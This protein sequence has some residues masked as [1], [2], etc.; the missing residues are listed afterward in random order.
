[1]EQVPGSEYDEDNGDGDE[2]DSYEMKTVSSD[3]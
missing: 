1:M 3:G 2:D